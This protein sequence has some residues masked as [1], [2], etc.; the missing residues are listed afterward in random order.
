MKEQ[1]QDEDGDEDEEQTTLVSLCATTRTVASE[2]LR[3]RFY[4]LFTDLDT[5]S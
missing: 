3:L 1:A 2:K 4:I 5:T